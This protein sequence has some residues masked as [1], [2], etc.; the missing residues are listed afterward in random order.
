[1]R[2]VVIRLREVLWADDAV[3]RYG[4]DEFSV[5]LAGANDERAR[6]A[7]SKIRKAVKEPMNVGGEIVTP[8]VSIGIALYPKD[9]ETADALMTKAYQDMERGKRERRDSAGNTE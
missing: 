2:E 7:A 6:N 4:G 3:G 8:D 9:G 5:L 1:M